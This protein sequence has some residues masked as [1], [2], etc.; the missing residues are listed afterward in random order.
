MCIFAGAVEVKR[1]LEQVTGLELPPTLVFD[2][3]SMKELADFLL[4]QLPA[5]AFKPAPAVAAAGLGS[6]SLQPSPTAAMSAAASAAAGPPWAA[7]TSEQQ[8]TFFRQQVTL[9]PFPT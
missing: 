1:D 8:T 3:P 9:K 2:Y 4:Q 5:P 7:M 6:Q